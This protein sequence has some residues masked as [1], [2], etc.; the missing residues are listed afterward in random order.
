MNFFNIDMHISIIHDVKNIFTSLGH[1]V[2]SVCMSG[3][4]WVNREKQKT[5]EIINPGN[6]KFIN[7]EMCDLFYN[8]YKE[9]LNKYDAFVHSYPPAFALLF[10][11]FQ[12]PVI[13]IACTR[14]DYPC[15]NNLKWLINGLQRM[16]S[17]NILIPIANNLFDKKYCE[18]YTEFEWKHI[19]SLCD[20]M[21]TQY[22][23]SPQKQVIIW[24]RSNVKLNHSQINNTFNIARPYN[25]CDVIK[26]Y[27][28]VIHI[29]YNIS[30]MSAFEHYYSNFPMF[31]P[32]IKCI[33]K[34]IRTGYN[35]LS[36]LYFNPYTLKIKKEWLELADWLV[37]DIMPYTIKFNSEEE[38]YELLQQ[39]KKY[40]ETTE[41][42]KENNATRKTQIYKQWSD[43]ICNL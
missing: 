12:K 1:N 23:Y 22:N 15:H 4:T 5:T 41:K 35:V 34:W 38:L 24:D 10:E 7:Q 31:V 18:E 39:S 25:R 43:I 20:Y 6:W 36:E 21:D 32:T 3:H 27:N 9:E 28:G 42:M 11:K 13:T 29:P 33:E 19:Q 16:K 26:T 40:K 37:D 2:D 8:R 30:I 17:Q 14:F